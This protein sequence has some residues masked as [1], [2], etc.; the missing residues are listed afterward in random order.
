[1]TTYDR[2]CPIPTQRVETTQFESRRYDTSLTANGYE[3]IGREHSMR[4]RAL[5]RPVAA[6]CVGLLMTSILV[7]C[8]NG[9]RP[10]SVSQEERKECGRERSVLGERVEVE[11]A[12]IALAVVEPGSDWPAFVR[13]AA[14]DVVALSQ[15][16][17]DTDSL[18]ACSEDL[19]DE[20]IHRYAC[21]ASHLFTA[22]ARTDGGPLILSAD[23]GAS[24]ALRLGL[25]GLASTLATPHEKR[26]FANDVGAR[27]RWHPVARG[28]PRWTGVGNQTYP[29]SRI[30]SRPVP[31]TWLDSTL[32]IERPFAG[33]HRR[34]AFTPDS[35]QERY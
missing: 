6:S 28:A 2:W 21:T 15:T 16:R 1:M 31:W 33:C 19:D 10:P 9:A 4:F 34:L 25:I 5:R 29:R 12:S 8:P 23:K 27:R 11:M 30:C 17:E 20:S 14:H 26:K 3:Y 32:P 35:N 13:G 22:V 24:P 18:L 7:E